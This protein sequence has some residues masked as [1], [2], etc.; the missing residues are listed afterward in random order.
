[1]LNILFVLGFD[2]VP[3][4]HASDAGDPNQPINNEPPEESLLNKVDQSQM[5]QNPHVQSFFEERNAIEHM[6]SCI[7]QS[8][9]A[10]VI[11]RAHKRY[12][13]ITKQ[14]SVP[15]PIN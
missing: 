15:L 11:L 2:Y 6:Q 13:L 4:E 1:M 3:S 12:T 5:P 14:G 10:S 9:T 7:S 8:E